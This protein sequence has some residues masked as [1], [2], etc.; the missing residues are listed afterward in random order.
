MMIPIHTI[1]MNVPSNFF[2]IALDSITIDGRE[3]VVTAIIKDKI[4]PSP[5]PF[6]SRLSATGMVPKI[7][8]Y[9]GTPTAVASG[10][11]YQVCFPR[12]LRTICSG[13]RLWIAA[14]MMTPTTI[15]GATFLT[16]ATT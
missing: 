4:V 11:A 10:T 8:A 6:A 5:A 7:S 1:P 12:M 14:P 15:Y 2:L 9:M 3:S 13:I 16:V